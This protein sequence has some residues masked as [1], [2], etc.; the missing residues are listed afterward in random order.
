MEVV[1]LLEIEYFL[2]WAFSCG[3]MAKETHL[4]VINLFVLNTCVRIFP[5]IFQINWFSN[6][7][8]LFLPLLILLT[9]QKTVLN[10]ERPRI[11]FLN[12]S[13]A[14]DASFTARRYNRSNPLYF[15]SVEFELLR[16]V[17]NS[18]VVRL[19]LAFYITF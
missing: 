6:I 11:L 10:F 3:I 18:F 8:K 19:L 9:L 1:L 5:V 14:K 17:D 15:V 4:Y 16:P 7:L 2:F 13:I 12:E